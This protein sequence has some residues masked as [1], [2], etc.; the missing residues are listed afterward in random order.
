[1]EV[2][3]LAQC[4]SCRKALAW[5]EERGARARFHDLRGEPLDSAGVERLAQQAGG[6]DALF[7]R[8]ALQYR[9]R[10]LHLRPPAEAEML[11]LMAEEP[12]FITR[13]VVVRNGR[14]VAGFAPRRLEALLAE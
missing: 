14:A 3:G 11:R 4:S 9:A 2:Y 5:L 7:S 6:V 8:R 1:V 13:P 12:T 10:G